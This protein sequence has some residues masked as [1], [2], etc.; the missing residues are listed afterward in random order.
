MEGRLTNSVQVLDQKFN[1]ITEENQIPLIIQTMDSLTSLGSVHFNLILL[2]FLTSFGNLLIAKNLAIGL[3]ATWATIY[4]LKKLVGRKRPEHHIEHVISRASFP[5]GHSGT[6]FLTATVL[7]AYFNREIIFF[8]LAAT[9]AFSRIYLED[10]YLS[11]AIV[12]SG[13]GLLI[14]Q[15]L[16]TI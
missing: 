3:T 15:I 5:S 12:G 9:V 14:G 1:Q 10:H 4:L 7:S 13:I 8:T 11:D 16:V 2:A 6:A